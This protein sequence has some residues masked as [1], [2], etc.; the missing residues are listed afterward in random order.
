MQDKD[1]EHN[2]R[3]NYQDNDR[4]FFITEIYH[5]SYV[6]GGKLHPVKEDGYL[7]LATICFDQKIRVWSIFLEDIETP[8][9]NLEYEMSINDNSEYVLGAKKSIYEQDEEL[10]D[11]TL[12]LLM[13]PQDYL[14]K[15]KNDPGM[16]TERSEQTE[17]D[18]ARF[19]KYKQVIEK[20]HPNAL[21]FDQEGRL[22]VGDSQGQINVWRVV[23]K[24]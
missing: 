13:N 8:D 24:F 19:M 22:F 14:M 18:K 3:L 1:T 10:E 16:T 9:Y 20:R 23:I 6:Y 2:D 15:A 7:Y 21:C 4:L 11:E 5:P 12:R 17:E